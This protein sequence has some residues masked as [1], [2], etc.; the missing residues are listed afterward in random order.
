MLRLSRLA[1]PLL[2]SCAFIAA[3]LHA[4]VASP[5][6]TARVQGINS[7]EAAEKLQLAQLDIV[8]RIHGTIAETTITARFANPGDR[9]L[10]GDFTLAMPA[11]SVV[12]GY[13]LDVGG[14]MIDGVLVDQRQARMAYEARVR[15]RIDP[16]LAEVSRDHLFRTRVFPILPRAGRTIQLKF[17]TPL[18]PRIGYVLPLRDTAEIA[19]FTLQVEASGMAAPPALRLPG[20]REPEWRSEGGT[21]RF[22][23][24]RH[25]AAF[26]GALEIG[27]PGRAETM[28]ASRNPAGET[29]FQIDDAVRAPEAGLAVQPGSVAILWDRSLSRGDDDLEAEIGLARQY[30]ERMRPASIELI[31]FDAGGIERR[32]VSGPAELARSLEAVRYRGA[33]SLAVLDGIDLSGTGA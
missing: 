22:G 7:P 30:L 29:F 11:G 5:A 13:A 14:R 26:E 17:T 33:T 25:E 4:Q 19:A 3:P 23:L 27:A 24:S 9:I 16:G 28:L 8:V 10:E 1:F 12:T 6:L 32:R 20:D 21:H 18:D 15:Q 31:L 2:A